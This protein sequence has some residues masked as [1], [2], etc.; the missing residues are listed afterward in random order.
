MNKMDWFWIV[1]GVIA[2]ILLIG[3]VVSLGSDYRE[4]SLEKWNSEHSEWDWNGSVG[5]WNGDWYESGEGEWLCL[6]LKGCEVL[7]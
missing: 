7:K 6:N 3:I 4:R 1:V 2:V 5:V